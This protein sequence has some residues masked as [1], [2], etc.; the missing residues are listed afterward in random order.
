MGTFVQ[1]TPHAA[2]L[3]VNGVPKTVHQSLPTSP[4]SAIS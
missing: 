3:T 2:T 4:R 1:I